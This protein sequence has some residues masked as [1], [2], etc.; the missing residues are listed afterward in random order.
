MKLDTVK[1]VIEGTIRYIIYKGNH[2]R[3]NIGFL[4]VML[5]NSTG[6]SKQGVIQ[7][8]LLAKEDV[9]KS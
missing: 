9:K 1:L 8:F 2:V 5:Q 4:V 6:H 3:A 7:Y